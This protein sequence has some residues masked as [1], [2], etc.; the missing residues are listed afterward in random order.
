MLYAYFWY[1]GLCIFTHKFFN[2][3]YNTLKDNLLKS[4][5]T[6][7]LTFLLFNTA[8]AQNFNL[9][10]GGEG[11]DCI[12][13]IIELENGDLVG[14]G[15]T[16][17]L[18]PAG[19][20][21]QNH[22]ETDI[23]FIRLDNS[24]SL[25]SNKLIGGEADDDVAK[26]FYKKNEN[27]LLLV[28]NTRSKINYESMYRVYND[29]LWTPLLD[30]EGNITQ[31]NFYRNFVADEIFDV[32]MSN[33]KIFIAAKLEEVEIDN[34]TLYL[35]DENGESDWRFS[36]FRL[37]SSFKFI[38]SDFV[39]NTF[40]VV[41]TGASDY[42]DYSD[43]ADILARSIDDNS[44]VLERDDFEIGSLKKVWGLSNGNGLVLRKDSNGQPVLTKV[45]SILNTI[46]D[47]EVENVKL[48]TT[49]YFYVP[50]ININVPAPFYLFE[51]DHDVLQFC[52]TNN[53]DD[54]NILSIDIDGNILSDKTYGGDS[55]EL[56]LNILPTEDDGYIMW[57]TSESSNSGDITQNNNGKK[58]IWV[59]K[60]DAE[61]NIEWQRLLGGSEDDEIK[62]ITPLA[63]G[64]Y[65]LSGFT[66]SSNSGDI[67]SE[68]QGESDAWLVKLN[69]DG[70]FDTNIEC[71]PPSVGT[72]M[73]DE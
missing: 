29:K 20:M 44:T 62:D 66:Y 32:I 58:D 21:P 27:E 38:D 9:I 50:M 41:G 11:N 24:G 15:T 48:T 35:M 63:N 39:N 25:L 57:A 33:N 40:W 61:K 64:G 37:G 56:L 18:N 30:I 42:V 1:L 55:S 8:S 3:M 51:L 22:G 2:T 23:W 31:L 47:I 70:N 34:A 49:K 45:D 14:I 10:L 6:L 60:L 53:N 28:G 67:L 72:F 68:N 26:M 17:S 19:A 59:I 4:T 73:C 52:F 71:V 65:V 69:K 36:L 43:E 12:N 54:I 5:N 16:T 7:M 46:W 13:Q